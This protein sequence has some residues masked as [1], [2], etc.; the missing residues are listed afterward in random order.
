MKNFLFLFAVASCMSA[1]AQLTSPTNVDPGHLTCKNNELLNRICREKGIDLN[2]DPSTIAYEKEIEELMKNSATRDPERGAVYIIPIVFHIVHVG[3]TENIS[4]EQVYDQVA[5]LNGDFRKQNA[6]TAAIITAF[7]SIAGDA[8]IEFR[9][10]QRDAL[11]NCV[12]GITRTFSATTNVGD[13]TVADAVAQNLNG[14][15]STTNI[16]YPRNKYLNV[17]VVKYAAGAAGYTNTPSAWTPADYD[18][19]WIQSTYVG[20][21][22]TGSVSR[23]RALTHEVGHWFN[24][25]HVWG[26]TNNAGVSCG[27]DSVSDTPVTEGWLTCNING[28]TCG[29]VVDNVQNFMEYA[30]CG[31]M[32][33]YGQGTRMRAAATSSTAGRNNLWTTANI[34]AAG[35]IGPSTLCKAD[36][37]SDAVVICAGDSIAFNDDSYNGATAWNWTF[38]SGTPSSSI[39]ESPVVKYTTPGTYSV[40]L[41]ASNSSGS[42][43]ETKTNYVTVLDPAGAPIPYSESFESVSTFP[44][45]DLFI[46]DS[47]ALYPWTLYTGAGSSGTKCLKLNNY[48]FYN[49]GAKDAIISKTFDLSTVSAAQ[50]SFRFA[51]K[52]RAGANVEKLRV[53]ISNNC[54]QTWS[55]RKQLQGSTLSMGAVSASAFTPSPADWQSFDVTNITSGYLTQGFRFKIEFE[56]DSGNNVYVDDINIMTNLGTVDLSN[57]GLELNVYPNPV[58]TYANV[59][60]TIP[61]AG[62][63]EVIVSDVLGKNVLTVEKGYKNAGAY[64]TKFNAAQLPAAGV[65]FVTIRSGNFSRTKKFIVN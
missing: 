2:T 59:D 64:S 40:S 10:A 54:G 12:S 18:G 1:N 43:I 6:D 17:W 50:L 5:I 65:Y 34:T 45:S 22:G 62:I 19:I 21:I 58:S 37:S 47:D 26:N 48:A 44:N 35:V 24:L 27:D 29:N 41:T 13:E 57:E 25:K 36:F 9:L 16:R 7:Q 39:N 33:S 56:S 31:K 32:F 63:T 30:Y 53:F 3:G 51:Y 42:D 20:S 4:D 38:T 52:Q 15:S 8:E 11:G 14:S 46:T 55:L 60:F 49:S 23:S 28:A 61:N